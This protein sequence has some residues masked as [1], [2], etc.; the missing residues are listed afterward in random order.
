MLEIERG[1]AGPLAP[2]RI[3]L[4][5]PTPVAAMSPREITEADYR[6]TGISLNGHP[7]SHVREMLRENGIRTAR[8]ISRCRMART[9]WRRRGW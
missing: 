4:D 1:D 7:M 2:S 6:M 5:V 8:E 3:K 9:M